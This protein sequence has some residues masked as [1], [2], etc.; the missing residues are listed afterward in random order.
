MEK[1][2]QG[3]VGALRERGGRGLEQAGHRIAVRIERDGGDLVEI[4][5]RET[6]QDAPGT[7]L[8]PE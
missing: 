4:L 8:D 6:A 5:F 7:D 1:R 2:A 3:D